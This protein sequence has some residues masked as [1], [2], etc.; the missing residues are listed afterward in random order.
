[1]KSQYKYAWIYITELLKSVV[2]TEVQHKITS[3]SLFTQMDA[4][5]MHMGSLFTFFK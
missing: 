2:V 4:K 1:M 5:N 3:H